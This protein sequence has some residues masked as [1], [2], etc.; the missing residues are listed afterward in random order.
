MEYY[1]AIQKWM[2]WNNAIQSNRDATRDYHPKRSKSEKGQGVPAVPQWVK[3][4]T[5]IH[6]DVGSIPGLTQWVMNLVLPQAVA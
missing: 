2:K 4:P 3:N 1:W 6:E 5:S